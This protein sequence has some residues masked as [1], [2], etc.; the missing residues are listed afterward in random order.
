M[1]LFTCNKKKTKSKEKRK[2]SV[3]SPGATK[4]PPVKIEK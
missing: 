1:K 2:E 4:I 3:G